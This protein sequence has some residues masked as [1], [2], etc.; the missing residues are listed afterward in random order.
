[1]QI[2]GEGNGGKVP[3]DSLGDGKNGNRG[4][5]NVCTGMIKKGGRVGAHT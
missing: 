5:H 3:E 4:S 2:K 1:M